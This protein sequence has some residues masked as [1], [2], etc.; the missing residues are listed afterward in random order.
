MAVDLNTLSYTELRALSQKAAEL[1]SAQE[2]TAKI[3]LREEIKRLI[4]KS[5][6][7]TQEILSPLIRKSG[8]AAATPKGSKLPAKYAKGNKAW[9]GRGRKPNWIIEHVQ[10]GGDIDSLLVK[11]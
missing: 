2:S 10:N 7:K 4:E 9:T 6:F 5:G 11:E 1:M 3:E 8:T